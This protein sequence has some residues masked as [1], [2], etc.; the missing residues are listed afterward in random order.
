MGFMIRLYVVFN[1]VLLVYAIGSMVADSGKA[2]A[3]MESHL[4]RSYHQNNLK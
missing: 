1:L 2:K 3:G 4:L